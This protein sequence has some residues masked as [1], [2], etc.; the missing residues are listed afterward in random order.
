MAIENCRLSGLPDLK[1]ENEWVTQQLLNWIHDLISKY[2]IDGIRID[3]IMEVP[4]WFWDSFRNS[5]RV[6]QIGEVFHG[7]INYVADYQNHLD[8]V[9]N[10]PLYYTIESSFCGSFYNLEGY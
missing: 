9:F 3:T 5:A 8:S 4:K 7:D 1:Q 6:F 10:Y 2:N